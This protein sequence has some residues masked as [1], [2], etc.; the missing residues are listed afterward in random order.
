MRAERAARKL[1]P[2]GEW[3]GLVTHVMV[4]AVMRKEYNVNEKGFVYISSNSDGLAVFGVFGSPE[5][6]AHELLVDVLDTLAERGGTVSETN[7][8][9]L[10]RA[11][12]D[13]GYELVVPN[14]ANVRLYLRDVND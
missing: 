12:S 4:Y 8:E 10:V 7:D 9:M 13:T 3:F 14:G 11:W 5:G 1:S 6:A 2:I